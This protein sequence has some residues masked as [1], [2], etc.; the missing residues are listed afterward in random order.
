MLIFS[1]QEMHHNERSI[2]QIPRAAK[3]ETEENKWETKET[4]SNL[5]GKMARN[6]VNCEE[7][8]LPHNTLYQLR[9][10]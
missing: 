7:S 8:N 10:S 5:N 6:C 3:A 4:S 2:A 9:G 1:E